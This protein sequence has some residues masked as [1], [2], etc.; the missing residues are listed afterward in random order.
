MNAKRVLTG[1]M[2]GALLGLIALPSLPA[3]ASVDA[4]ICTTPHLYDKGIVRTWI[5]SFGAKGAGGTAEGTDDWS[6]CE[7]PNP[8][9]SEH[10]ID[11]YR[12][13]QIDKWTSSG[14]V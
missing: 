10:I 12:Y 14:Y 7:S 1:A 8:W 5:D 3:L 4:S 2:A 9:S 6:T 11:Q 13:G